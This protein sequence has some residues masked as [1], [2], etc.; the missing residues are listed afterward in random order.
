MQ[1]ALHQDAGAAERNRLVDLFAN[2]FEGADVSVGCT[3][4]AIKRT[5]RADDVADVGVVDV[6]I[7]DVGNGVVRV[8]PGAYLVSRD[9]HPRDVVRFEQERAF[10]DGHTLAREH[11]I[12]NRF[13][14]C[15]RHSLTKVSHAKAQSRKG[16]AKQKHESF[17]CVAFAALRLCVTMSL[18]SNKPQ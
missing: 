18:I 11:A 7:D 8:T 17:L 16:D 6:A 1:T 3:R 5:E 14:V 4:A 2:L 9:A 15:G 13:D 12:Q 10:F